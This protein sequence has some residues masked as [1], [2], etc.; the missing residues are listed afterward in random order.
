MKNTKQINIYVSEKDF[1]LIEFMDKNRGRKSQAAY[2]LDLIENQMKEL[3][4]A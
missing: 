1:H 2:I 3:E 4:K